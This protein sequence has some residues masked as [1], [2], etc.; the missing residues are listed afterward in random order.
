MKAWIGVMLLLLPAAAGCASGPVDRLMP[1]IETFDLAKSW[2]GPPT[3]SRVIA[4]GAQVSPQAPSVRSVQ[5]AGTAVNATV[6]SAH[7]QTVAGSSGQSADA[8]ALPPGARVEYEWLLDDVTTVPGQDVV[9]RFLVGRDRQG[10]PVY[11]ER[12][13]WVPAH[14]ARRFC[15]VRLLAD[16]QGRIMSRS[17]EGNDCEDLLKRPSTY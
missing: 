16:A 5:S 3:S 14:Q 4:G 12:I 9:E 7:Q 13:R 11:Y 2:F 10:F 1:H 17:A 8:A 15:R 6:K